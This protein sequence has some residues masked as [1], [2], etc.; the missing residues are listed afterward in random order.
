MIFQ[1]S[2]ESF[3]PPEN[4][5]FLIQIQQYTKLNRQLQSQILQLK[6]NLQDTNVNSMDQY[7]ENLFENTEENPD[8]NIREEIVIQRRMDGSE[9]FNRTWHEYQLGFGNSSGEFFIGL[10]KLHELTKSD[11]Y[12]LL[13]IME[14]WDNQMRYAKYDTFVVGGESEFYELQ[15]LGRYTGTAGDSLSYSLGGKFTTIDKDNDEAESFNCAVRL[16]GAWWHKFC[17]YR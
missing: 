14:D 8:S 6:K 4:I 5:D 3:V 12:G 7:D 16:G 10:D 9:D 13:I 15:S 11:C 1:I 2:D 17:S